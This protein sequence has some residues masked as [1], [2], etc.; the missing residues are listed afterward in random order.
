MIDKNTLL[1]SILET[2]GKDSN[3]TMDEK[4]NIF[5]YDS[6]TKVNIILVLETFAENEN[7]SIDALVNCDTYSD[8]INL[9]E[10]MYKEVHTCV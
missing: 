9:T 8:L 2:L 6:F 1:N 7:L 3:C 4:F 10:N 5:E